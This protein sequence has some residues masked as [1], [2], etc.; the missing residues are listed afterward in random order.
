VV[1]ESLVKGIARQRLSAT[2]T[3]RRP[4]HATGT[5]RGPDRELALDV[6]HRTAPLGTAPHRNVVRL[7]DYPQQVPIG[8]VRLAVAGAF[9]NHVSGS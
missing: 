1:R 7:K 2:G 3:R 9:G 6:P 4:T 5:R 8:V